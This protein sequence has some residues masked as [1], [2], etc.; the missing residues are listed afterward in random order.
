MNE[1]LI[2]E[3]LNAFDKEK[4][5]EFIIEFFFNNKIL[6]TTKGFYFHSTLNT[7]IFD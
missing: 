4:K 6:Y 5:C 1:E 3:L 7:F 2:M